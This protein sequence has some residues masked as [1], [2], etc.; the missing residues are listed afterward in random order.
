[1]NDALAAVGR[2][3]PR[4]HQTPRY[5][6]NRIRE[7][8]YEQAHPEDPWLT[9]AAI[10]LLATLLRPAIPSRKQGEARARSTWRPTR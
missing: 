9:P 1:M 7:M 6:G 10:Q 8:L 5:A 3:R 4:S 2:W